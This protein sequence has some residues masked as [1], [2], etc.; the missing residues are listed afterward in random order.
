MDLNE[1]W[2][3]AVV[4]PPPGLGGPGQHS[5]KLARSF[6]SGR[7]AAFLR[8]QILSGELSAGTPLVEHRLAQTLSVSRGPVRSALNALEGEGLVR[9]RPNGR[10]ESVG[11]TADDLRD[12]LAV[13]RELESRAVTWGI[14]ARRDLGEVL[15]AYSAIEAAGASTPRLVDLDIA[16][17]KTMVEFSGSRFLVQA[18]LAIA[19]VIQAVI[20]LANRH[21]AAQD[22]ESNFVRIVDSHR[23]LVDALTAYDGE[24]A[25]RALNEQFEL[26]GSMFPLFDRTPAQ[27]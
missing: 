6:Y 26:T 7:I 1:T 21:L 12:L 3:E 23:V 15:G 25:A 9:T 10:T 2:N 14:S 4:Q 13:R 11:F 5:V 27:A 22:P 19:P 17:H 18:W 20:T 8:E 16:F 24:A